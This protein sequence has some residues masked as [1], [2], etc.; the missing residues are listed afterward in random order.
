MNKRT[1]RIGESEFVLEFG[2]LTTSTASVLV[3]SDDYMLTMG[4]GV[5]SAIRRAGG[6][7]ILLDAAKK[8]PAKVGDIVVTSAGALFAKHIFHAITLGPKGR[9][10]DVTNHTRFFGDKGILECEYVF[11]E[12]IKKLKAG[13]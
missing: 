4:G 10:K 13:T 11:I 8:I 12:A 6:E 1:Y 9:E 3:S 2:D 7:M 5:S